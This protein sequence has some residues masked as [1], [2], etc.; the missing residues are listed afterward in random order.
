M[1]TKWVKFASDE[2]EL[3][4]LLRGK[5]CMPMK[6]NSKAVLLVKHDGEYYMV[7]N[8]CPH[9]GYRLD[10]AH[11][12]EGAIVCP[13]HKYSFSLETGRGSGLYLENYPIEKR[14]DGYYAGFEY[15]SLF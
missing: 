13:W 5:E 3:N 8:R 15:F 12:E 7:K 1:K 2:K 14:E 11:C 6:V 10:Q 9:Q 4:E